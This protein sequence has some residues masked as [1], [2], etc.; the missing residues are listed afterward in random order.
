[1]Q[2]GE[3]GPVP[4]PHYPLSSPGANTVKNKGR[5][6]RAGRFNKSKR[7]SNKESRPPHS[8]WRVSKAT[9]DA[10]EEEEADEE[11]LYP[12][13]CYLCCCFWR[14]KNVRVQLVARIALSNCTL[15]FIGQQS[16]HTEQSQSSVTSYPMSQEHKRT[17]RDGV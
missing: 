11:A 2:K 5:N 17:S 3:R 8:N 4:S 14:D 7:Q 13:G 15:L 12:S 6:S 9:P 1:M 16:R 10:E